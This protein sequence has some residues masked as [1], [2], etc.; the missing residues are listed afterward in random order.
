MFFCPLPEG[1]G[2]FIARRQLDNYKLIISVSKKG[3]T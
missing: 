2:P 1:R 3:F